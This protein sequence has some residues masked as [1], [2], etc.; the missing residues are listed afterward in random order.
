MG[1]FDR[2]ANAWHIFT[3]SI[4]FI[5]KDKSLLAI[6]ILLVLSSVVL[7]IAFFAMFFAPRVGGAFVANIVVFLFIMYAWTTFLGA[8]QSWMVH[9]VAQGKDTTVR[10]GFGRALKN[11]GD[12][13]AFAV[14]MLLIGAIA[15]RLRQKGALGQIAGGFLETIAGIAGKL[16]LPAMIITERSFVQAVQQLR[17]AIR[18]IPEIA[19]YEIGIRPLTGLVV[20]I[21][22]GFAALLLFTAG[23]IAAVAFF[24]LWIL[25]VVILSIQIN[26]IYYTLL[27]LTLIEKKRVPG[28]R[29]VR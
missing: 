10:S 16:V 19:T 2:L 8:A 4:S 26:Q 27:Y 20:W 18:A 14:V 3:T 24:V 15:G 7:C 21:G 23:L 22:L 28:L 11:I 5:A 9:E 1:I 12:V 29:I 25:A 13:L 6:P 17:H